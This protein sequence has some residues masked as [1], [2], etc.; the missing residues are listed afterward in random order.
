LDSWKEIASY[1]KC[2]VRTV[3]RWEGEG[4]PVH[5]HAH[6]TKP[7]IYA[8]KAEIDVW[9]RNGHERV[10]QVE[11]SQEKPKIATKSKIT[12]VIAAVAVVALTVAGGL[13]WHPRKA[14]KLTDKDTLVLADFANAT[15]DADF[16]DVLKQGLRAGLQQSPFLNILSDVQIAEELRLMERAPDQRLTPE[17]ARE[18]CQRVGSKA[19]LAGSLS[20][21]DAHYIIG[22][23][24]FNCQT[25]GLL[26]S[27]QEEAERR[28]NVLRA[29][30]I[31]A[32][33]IRQKLGE[34]LASVQKYDVPLEQATTPSLEALKAYS[35]AMKNWRVNG[36]TDAI[37]FFQRAI[38]LDD[39]FASAYADLADLYED[40]GESTLAG[41]YARKAFQCRDR[42]TQRE[43]FSITVAYHFHETGDLQKGIQTTELWAQTYPRDSWAYHH[44]SVMN[45]F[46]GRYEE[47]VADCLQALRFDPDGPSLHSD[48]M[49]DYQAL[50][51]LADAKAV[52][53]HA[54]ERN[55]DSVF[56]HN[57]MYT[58]AFLEGDDGEMARQV[59]WASG[60]R[61]AE[62]V[63]LAAQSDTE[64]FFGRSGKARQLS[65]RAVEFADASG[66]KATAALWQSGEA[67]RDAELGN[68]V[69]ARQEAEA[70]L[71]RAPTRD[72][73]ILAALAF[74]RAGD[75][76]RAQTLSE[77]LGKHQPYNTE[78]NS[79]W[80][81][82]I[83]AAIQI[84]RG[85][86]AQAIELLEVAKPFDL[87]F[88]RPQVG[89]GGLLYPVWLRG[90]AFLLL[91]R[92]NEA[93][94]EFQRILDHR[95]AIAN[96]PISVLAHLQLARA[97]A[98]QG[99]TSE[100]RV[101]YQDFFTRW[102]DADSDIP[103]LR[104]AKAEFE[105]LK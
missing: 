81:P 23:N 51:L 96:S 82:S 20:R 54:L 17:L 46:L 93:A 7:G 42:A 92:S 89:G 15:G 88:P 100:A 66:Q 101:A 60:R 28:E 57:D 9:W 12:V 32:T 53:R 14:P 64:A 3:R 65:R 72:V 103:V 86:A 99:D 78:L 49:E 8:Y 43:K 71:A 55:I 52:Y 26:G 39:C 74:A 77:D 13:L 31:S 85:N 79:Y 6:K 19:V 69:R 75:T 38:E 29:L 62:D 87:A 98:M 91:N 22:L 63:L 11:P 5:R 35:L 41:E 68:S 44:K 10:K 36:V 2:S 30:S 61:G 56:L 4:L 94:A 102:K 47:A 45:E 18:L 104:Q 34:S 90:L 80:L 27:E 16:D 83:R 67:L 95:S 97:Y 48:L 24:V 73:Q 25:G 59:A 33:K 76:A 58:I 1:L 105:S 40:L 70:G 21:L 50:N 84:S 37:P